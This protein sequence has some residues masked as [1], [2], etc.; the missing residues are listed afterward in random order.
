MDTLGDGTPTVPGVEHQDSPLSFQIV[1]LLQSRW[2]HLACDLVL[3]NTPQDVSQ[4]VVQILCPD[5]SHV[6]IQ[7]LCQQCVSSIGDYKENLAWLELA[8]VAIHSRSFSRVVVQSTSL[9]L[10]ERACLSVLSQEKRTTIHNVSH[11]F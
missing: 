4:R 2:I 8:L 6:C 11:T 5:Q 1:V 3:T 7:C 10:T 9:E